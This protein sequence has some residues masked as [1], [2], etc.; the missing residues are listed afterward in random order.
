MRR[1][2]YDVAVSLDGY[3]AAEGDDISAYPAEG[4][5]VAAFLARLETYETVIMGRRTYEFGYRFGL[6][7]GAR[8]YP[9]MDHYVFS[10]SLSL[11]G[12]DV[13]VVRDDWLGAL[14]T[15]RAGAGGDIYLCSG[16]AFAGFVAAHGLFDIVR[17]K[18]A[19]SGQASPHRAAP[20]RLRSISLSRERGGLCTVDCLQGGGIGGGASSCTSMAKAY[21]SARRGAD[22]LKWKIVRQRAPGGALHAG[23]RQ[24]IPSHSMAGSAADGRATRPEPKARESLP[25][26]GIVV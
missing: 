6:A 19:P 13:Q 20:S 16:G 4:D 1:I 22:S 10:R 11:P 25:P 17:V 3:I 23:R 15:L 14:R 12:S 5:H 18:L 7:P 9:H 2:V 21:R 24:S 26:Q 8:A